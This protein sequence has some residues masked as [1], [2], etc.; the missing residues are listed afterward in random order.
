MMTVKEVAD[1]LGV[2]SIVAYGLLHFMTEKEFVETGRAAK[3]PNKKGKPATTYKLDR[4][5]IDR[6]HACLLKNFCEGVNVVKV[7]GSDSSEQEVISCA[8]PVNP[9]HEVVAAV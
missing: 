3:V 7:A 4:A 1:K 9:A 5:C 2:D 6:L 8:I